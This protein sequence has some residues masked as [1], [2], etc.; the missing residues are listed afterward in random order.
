[1]SQFDVY[2]EKCPS[3]KLLDIISNKWTI[4]IV[5]KLSTKTCRFGELKKEIG[6]ISQKVLTQTLKTLEKNG[7]IARKSYDELQLKVEY[8]LTLTGK[9]LAEIFSTITAWAERHMELLSA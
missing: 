5:E 3:R 8:S 7:F 1:M 6:G 4:L 2:N 9:S